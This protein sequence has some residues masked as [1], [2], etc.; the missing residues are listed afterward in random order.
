MVFLFASDTL[1]ATSGGRTLALGR[2]KVV[3]RIEK[4]KI[5]EVFICGQFSSI[6]M[7]RKGRIVRKAFITCCV[8][9]NV[10]WTILSI[11]RSA[12]PRRLSLFYFGYG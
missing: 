4:K 12:V 3:A 8:E 9:N 10:P 6:A 7:K 5:S 11:R 1:S 2:K